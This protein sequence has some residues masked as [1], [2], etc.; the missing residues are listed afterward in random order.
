MSAPVLTLE[1]E[2]EATRVVREIGEAIECERENARESFDELATRLDM[3]PSSV[4]SVAHGYQI[5]LK[6]GNAIRVLGAYGLTLAVVRK[7]ER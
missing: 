2:A 4:R 6:V 1:Q 7:V 3:F 5:N